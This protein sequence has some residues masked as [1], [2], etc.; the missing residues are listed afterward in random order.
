MQPF[1]CLFII[2]AL[3][4]FAPVAFAGS[5]AV[6]PDGPTESAAALA[7]ENQKL[8]EQLSTLAGNTRLVFG[9]LKAEREMMQK[10][11]DRLQARLNVLDAPPIPLSAEE[12]LL[13]RNPAGRLTAAATEAKPKLPPK[14]IAEA[15]QLFARRQYEQAE[16][17]YL[18]ILKLDD[19][20]VCTLGNLA[21]IS[22]ELGKFADT[23]K[24]VGLAL[25][26]HPKDSF[27]LGVLGNLR[28]REGKYQ[29]ALEAL[30]QAA[31]LDPQDATIQNFLG[32]TLS[33]LGQL[34][35]AETALRKALQLDPEYSSAHNNLAVIYVTQ[36][37]PQIELA[38]WHYQKAL[39]AGQDHNLDLE[40]L[41]E[42]SA[43][44]PGEKPAPPPP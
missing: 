12:S 1:I 5:E 27:S 36:K 30:S 10:Q 8:R 39:V 19:R 4:R 44:P 14:L 22:I 18:E 43:P 21:T 40:K 25:A 33:R 17:K 11:L 37:P 7:K 23:E 15:Q 29:Q 41:L 6:N 26:I 20:N 9:Q 2:V 13:F 24:Y 38:R 42:E 31:Q 16:A 34:G 35:A 3:A 32:V 28:F